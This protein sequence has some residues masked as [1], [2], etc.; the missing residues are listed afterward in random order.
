MAFSVLFSCKALKGGEAGDL[1][2]RIEQR[3][4]CMNTNMHKSL[5][6]YSAKGKWIVSYS[7]TY[8]FTLVF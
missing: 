4:L 2:V 6:D 1:L 7:N 8:V 3:Y 5:P